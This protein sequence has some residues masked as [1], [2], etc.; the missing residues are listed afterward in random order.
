MQLTL[1]F[2]DNTPRGKGDTRNSVQKNQLH[3]LCITLVSD[4]AFGLSRT[5]R[6]R[7]DC[8]WLQD[9]QSASYI[10]DKVFLR[11]V[12]R[13]PVGMKR[14]NTFSQTQSADTSLL[15]KLYKLL[16]CWLR[17]MFLLYSQ[18]KIAYLF[19]L[20]MFHFCTARILIR[21]Y[22]VGRNH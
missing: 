22:A 10:L 17:H 20:G 4:H 18:G 11:L 13:I 19:G 3:N 16:T 15:G 9:P 1:S 8:T 21:P 2:P 6:R 14:K 7:R 12:R 5:L